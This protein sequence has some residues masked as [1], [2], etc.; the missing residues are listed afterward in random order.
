MARVKGVVSKAR[1][2][3]MARESGKPV[4][5]YCLSKR[6]DSRIL[7]RSIWPDGSIKDETGKN[8]T[9]VSMSPKAKRFTNYWHAYAYKC[10]LDALK[11]Q[12][13]PYD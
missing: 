7:K 12:E 6:W 3:K 8:F 5:Y 2:L 4:I 13:E 1:L 9:I 11:R 10:Q